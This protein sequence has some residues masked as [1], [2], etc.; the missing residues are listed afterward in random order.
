MPLGKSERTRALEKLEGALKLIEN[1]KRREIEALRSDVCCIL[2][3]GNQTFRGQFLDELRMVELHD[4][5]VCAEET[6]IEGLA[7][8]LVHEAQHAR[9]FRLGFDYAPRNRGRIERICFRAERNFAKLLPGGDELVARANE[10]MQS[11]AEGHFS[12]RARM[13][14]NLRALRELGCP[15]AVIRLAR[16]MGERRVP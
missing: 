2:V 10:W 6:T 16:W 14:A 13:E 9:L 5:Y 12:P 11:A 15:E 1:L 4:D 8:T 7:C 3:A